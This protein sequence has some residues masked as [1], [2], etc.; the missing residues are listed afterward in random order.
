MNSPSTSCVLY[1]H[2]CNPNVLMRSVICASA[3][4]SLNPSAAS[5]CGRK[6]G[7]LWMNHVKSGS[8]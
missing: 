4:G 7:T 1:R 5:S 8:R 3:D 6:F 2:S